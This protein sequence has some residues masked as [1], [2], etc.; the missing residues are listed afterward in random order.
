MLFIFFIFEVSLAYHW[1]LSAQEAVENGVRRAAVNAPVVNELT[2]SN[3]L[4]LSTINRTVGPGVVV[5]GACFEGNCQPLPTMGCSRG[6]RLAE[7]VPLG[8][9]CNAARFDGVFD[10][11]ARLALVIEPEDLTISSQYLD[12]GYAV[13]PYV[14]EVTISIRSRA[15]PLALG[16]FGHQTQLPAVAA[17]LVTEDLTN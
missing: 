16:L 2:R 11:V 3:G 15:F 7:N 6:L 12:L 13:A 10:E 14:L 8:I 9:S 17:T 5:G 1:A 4:T